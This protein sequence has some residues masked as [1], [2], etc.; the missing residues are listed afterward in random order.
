MNDVSTK[1]PPYRVNVKVNGVPVTMEIDT[2]SA[3]SLINKKSLISLPKIEPCTSTFKTYTGETIRVLG[4]FMARVEHA[5][6]I[7]QL[8]VHVV[9]HA[10]VNLLGRDWIKHLPNLLNE[11]RLVFEDSL[12]IILHRHADVFD[13]TKLGK[14]KDFKAKIHLREPHMP[15]FCKPRTLP[16][17]LR[18]MVEAELKRLEQEGTIEPVQHAEWAAP[19]VPVLKP[20]GHVRICGDY[21]LTVNRYALID[22]YPLPKIEDLYATLAGGEKF[23][24]LDL[25]HAYSQVEL[26][27]HS[28]DLTT[29]STHI[30]LYKYK[31]LPFG[32]NAAPGIF[33]RIID[34]LVRD[35]PN[36]CAY[37]DDILITGRTEKEHL[38][39]LNRVLQR[40]SD[41]G[42]RLKKSKCV[43]LVDSVDYLGYRLDKKGLHPLP[44]K[45]KPILD[46]PAPRNENELR[47][48][49]GMLSHYRR[50][51]PNLSIILSPLYDLL[52]KQSNWR[53]SR[54]EQRAFEEAKRLLISPK[55]LVHY[56]PG[57]LL[58]M[59]CDASPHGVG[60]VLGHT[61]S[62][63]IIRPIAFASR[64][65]QP[66]EKNYSQLDKEALAVVFGIKRFHQYLWGNFF[67][68]H[69]DHKPLLS[70]LGENRGIE[71]LNAPRMVRWA[72]LLSAYNYRI[73]YIP[74]Q[75]NLI[76]DALSRL[77]HRTTADATNEVPVEFVH[78]LQR[79][80]SS[81]TSSM[82][83]RRETD[84]DPVLSQVKRMMLHGWPIKVT[85]EL[86]P[87]FN[88]R[89]ELS[90]HEGCILRGSRIIVPE[91]VR[92]KLLNELHD[93][94]PGVVRMKALARSYVW[95]P[96]LDQHIEHLVRC[97]DYCQQ[98]Q[99][100]KPTGPIHPWALPDGPW[101]RVHADYFGPVEGKMLLLIIDAYSKWIDVHIVPNATAESTIN[102]VRSSFAIYGV[103]KTLCTDNGPQFSSAAFKDFL[104]SNGVHHITSAPYHPSSNG[105]AERA[106]QTVK[107]GLHKQRPASLQTKLDRF[108]FAY[109][110][111]PL[112]S[113]NKS[114]G[115]VMF[116][117]R[118]RTRLD[119]IFPDPRESMR[120]NMY[121]TQK[122]LPQIRLSGEKE[123]DSK[124]YT[125]LPHER[126]WVPGTVLE[127][128]GTQTTLE[129]GD[130]RTVRRH[131]DHVRSRPA[132]VVTA[133]APSE[134]V[135]NH[136]EAHSDTEQALPVC[137]Q[138]IAVRKPARSPKPIDRFVPGQ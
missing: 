137:D 114:P 47:S 8:P 92:T 68:L 46:T 6:A 73:R 109:R 128:S 105:L 62:D 71:Q 52:K 25:S 49:I 1:V 127:Q 132:E 57:K 24:K 31:R 136:E 120:R 34:N 85:E 115:E 106:V 51:I 9:D 116:G 108:L 74:G 55:V 76:A 112:E 21:K 77:P 14:L 122:G 121:R 113:I 91:S 124:V 37:L 82:E 60:A 72:L 97:C 22:R 75:K 15:K 95:W 134:S 99:N 10:A 28:Q 4:K 11:V 67:E 70:L 81:P 5:G 3:V 79:L 58:I 38:A 138:P 119:L 87:Y 126:L 63:G 110:T 78:L 56:D 50:F 33:Q 36:T 117:R 88:C 13:D 69:T 32:I 102:K 107:N 94:H 7:R 48:F 43:F 27:E 111:T 118:L 83:V 100:N 40:L 135:R 45:V 65:L 101:Q 53:W 125:K 30:G 23:S 103:P 133:A 131:T 17:K 104:R 44:D 2:G 129:L 16:Y 61:D 93:A 80:D 89:S 18:P 42:L 96:Q 54:S 98:H 84:R 130:G 86:R 64:T 29:I 35:I 39:T 41:K 26:D 59:Q 12:K 90:L 20:D 123:L 66:A 19:I